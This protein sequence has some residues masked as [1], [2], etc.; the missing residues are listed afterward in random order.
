MQYDHAIPGSVSA[1][2]PSTKEMS[3]HELIRLIA[4]DD[5]NAMRV[6]FAR[7]NV[8]VFRFAVRIVGNEATGAPFCANALSNC[9]RLIGRSSISSIIMS[10]RSTTSR[11][12]SACR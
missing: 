3:D 10:G 8:R 4:A 9:R 1:Q 11:A 7:H 5:N 2:R 6:L 12:S